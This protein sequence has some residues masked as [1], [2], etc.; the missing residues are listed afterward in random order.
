ML[1][2]GIVGNCKSCALVSDKASIDWFCYPRFD[3]PSV[4]AKILDKKKGGSFEIQTKGRYKITQR[5]KE[6]T[7]ILE[8]YF[9]SKNAKFVVIDFFPRYK[10]IVPSKKRKVFRLNKLI[11][12]IKPLKG[13]PFIKVKYD[14]RLNY[15]KGENTF[16]VV[17]DN[18]IVRNKRN[19]ISMISN[20]DYDY[21]THNMYFK[22][23]TVK[24]FVIGEPCDAQ[25]YNVKLCQRLMTATKYYWRL[26]VSSLVLPEKNKDIIIRS[27]LALKL[28]TYSETGSIMAAATTSIPEEIGTPRNWDYRFCWVRDSSFTIDSLKKIGRDYEARKLMEF[29]LENSIKRKKDM[30]IVYGIRGET[31]LTE[32]ILNHLSGFASTPPVR[33]G[34]AAFSQKQNDVYGSLIYT[35]YLY[36]VYY[37]YGRGKR[38]PKKFW[39]LLKYLVGKIDQ[40][41][42]DTD[43]GIWEF[44]SKRKHFVY[45]KLMCYVGIDRAVKIAQHY[46]ET[47]LAEK[48][49]FIADKIRQDILN[50]GWND[51]LSSFTMYYG[52]T[53]LD[54]ALLQMCY[55]DFLEADDPRLVSTVKKISDDL[56]ADSLVRRYSMKDD[57]GVSKSAFTICAFWMVDALYVIGEEKKAKRLFDKLVGYSN[58]L[59]LFSEDLDLR[60]KK[61]VGNF[62]QA[63]THVALINSAILLSEWS[64]KRKK[65]TH[66]EGV[67]KVRRIK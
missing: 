27:A 12:I 31:R 7:N 10:R 58:H 26:W 36:Y 43:H 65:L 3:S 39:K 49:I 57:L 24:Y 13:K 15:G 16:R 44:R 54:A 14:P 23:D 45:S 38:M 53:E 67:G 50:K 52:G 17:K 4:F 28:L 29:F 47:K 30:G 40:H 5:Y 22:L 62:P 1:K 18:L 51:R 32:K 59:G 48:W 55:H 6:Q 8:T 11:R 9:T 19:N 66:L 20:V 56:R 63:Y 61:L 41:W 33:V 64:A 60:T 35:M 46:G 21:I 37:E 42:K 34:N 2:Y 25:Q